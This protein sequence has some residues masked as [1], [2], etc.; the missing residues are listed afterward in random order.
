[1]SNLLYKYGIASIFA[2]LWGMSL[3]TWATWI[4]FTNP[5]DIPMGT[6]TAFTSMFALPSAVIGLYKWR[7]TSRSKTD[8][9]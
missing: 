8:E 1:M 4:V 2:M 3:F 6:V 9:Q 5:P 7:N